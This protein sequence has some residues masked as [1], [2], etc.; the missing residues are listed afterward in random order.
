MLQSNIDNSNNNNCNSQDRHNQ[1]DKEEWRFLEIGV[2]PALEN[3]SMKEK[4]RKE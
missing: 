1:T 2:K 3:R 4:G